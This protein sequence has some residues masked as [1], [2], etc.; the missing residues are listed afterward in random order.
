LFNRAQIFTSWCGRP[1]WI[2]PMRGRL[3]SSAVLVALLHAI[4]AQAQSPTNLVVLQGLVP[5]SGLLGDAAGKAALTANFDTT[6]AIQDGSAKQPL[7][8]PFPEQQQQALRDATI[9]DDNAYGLADGL[10]TGLGR[11]YQSVATYDSPD[12][13]QTHTFKSL[14]PAVATLIAYTNGITRSD[15]NSGKYFFANGT[16]NGKIPV[17]AAAADIMTKAKGV[18]DVFG[19]V[20]AASKGAEHCK[21]GADLYGNSRPF[22]TEPQL[23]LISGKDFFGVPSSNLDWLYGPKQ[24]LCDS[25]AFPSGHTTYGFAESWILALLLPQRYLEM[26]TRAAEYGNDRIILGAHYAMDVLG[27]R[28][29]ATYDIAQLLANK[30]PY[31]GI[32]RG[33]LAIDNYQEALATARAEATAVLEKQCGEKLSHCAHQ[34]D[35]RFSDPARNEAFYKATQ[36]YD[37]PAVHAQNVGRTEDV[38]QLAPEAGYLLTAAFPYLTLDQA[39]DILTKTEGP[40]GGFLDDGSA[41]GVYSRLNLY[42]AGEEAIRLAPK[43]EQAH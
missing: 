21:N 12:D 8:L 11:A 33:E 39:D 2:N 29:L 40:G 6:A 43:N 1:F 28:T 5:V 31:V 32:K 30:A 36:T 38:R 15:S 18:P 27:G 16:T 34:D 41:F 26:L 20:Y 14:S 10:G 22:Q 17:S 9:T 37:L 42:R 3:L 25:P 23:T 7:L 13:G 24:P 19:Q 35:G 4:P